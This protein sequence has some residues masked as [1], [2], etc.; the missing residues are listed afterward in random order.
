MRRKHCFTSHWPASVNY[1]YL[2]TTQI[3]TTNDMPFLLIMYQG[4]R[5]HTY[6][7]NLVTAGLNIYKS[8]TCTF[9]PIIVL[10]G[11]F[12]WILSWVYP[13]FCRMKSKCILKKR[14][15]W[16]YSDKL[17]EI[18]KLSVMH[19]YVTCYD[20]K[21]QNLDQ[22]SALIF[23]HVGSWTGHT[24]CDTAKFSRRGGGDSRRSGVFCEYALNKAIS[25]N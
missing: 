9:R 20:E 12:L 14:I 3:S 22:C 4:W 23:E 25:W 17:S 13:M 8:R 16:H 5:K 2:V 6:H 18:C 24:L 1:N 21:L 11:N 19:G 10:Y 15:N 7:N